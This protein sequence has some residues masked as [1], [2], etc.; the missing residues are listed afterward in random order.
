MRVE[1][2][3]DECHRMFEAVLDELLALDL[4]KKDRATLRRWRSDDASPGTP[5]MR[6]LATKLSEQIQQSHDRSEVS[7]IKKPDWVS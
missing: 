5:L 2:T 6:A 7:P 4:D 1:F 3:V